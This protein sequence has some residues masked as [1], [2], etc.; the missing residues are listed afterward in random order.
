MLGRCLLASLN[1]DVVVENA[2]QL[3]SAR[4]PESTQRPC[5]RSEAAA[6][7]DQPVGLIGTQRAFAGTQRH[8]AIDDKVVGRA[9][10]YNE[11]FNWE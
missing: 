10:A 2:L 5:E 4:K 9:G 1:R 7:F 3:I 11:T 6:R 8:Q